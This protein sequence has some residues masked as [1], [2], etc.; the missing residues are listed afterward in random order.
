MFIV[1][2]CKNVKH[3]HKHDIVVIYRIICPSYV[4]KDKKKGIF[5]CYS[6]TQ[7]SDII[8][9]FKH[10]SNF[11][12]FTKERKKDNEKKCMHAQCSSSHGVH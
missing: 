7:N 8:R 6:S 5:S 3:L 1:C 2:V 11:Q 9:L 12:T 4:K 10:T